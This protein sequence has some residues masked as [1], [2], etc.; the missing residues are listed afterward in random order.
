MDGRLA[1]IAEPFPNVWTGGR[2]NPFL[3]YVIPGPRAFDVNP[4]E[5]DL[6]PFA[7]PLD[8][9]RPYR[10]DVSVVGVPEG[11]SGWSAPVH[12]LVR[13]DARRAHVSGAL[14]GVEADDPPTSPR[15][16]PVR[17]SAST[18]RAATG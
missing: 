5:Y 18:R 1:G 4:I 16:R 9:G 15:T 3:R 12:V 7:G 17:R 2:P 10:V 6:S 14:T 11:R 8:D 13:Q